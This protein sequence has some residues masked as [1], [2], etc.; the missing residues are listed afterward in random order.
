MEA[1]EA[2]LAPLPEAEHTPNGADPTHEE[3][4]PVPPYEVEVARGEVVDDKQIDWHGLGLT[5]PP[6]LPASMMFDMTV[7][8]IEGDDSTSGW[9]RSTPSTSCSG[10]SSGSRPSVT[11][12]R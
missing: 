10:R 6:T 2:Q 8:E 3:A 1:S 9:R 11:P 7:A 5:L 12:R 4:P